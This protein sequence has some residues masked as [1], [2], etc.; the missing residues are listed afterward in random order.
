MLCK[1]GDN[2]RTVRISKEDPGCHIVYT[3]DGR[4]Q[5]VGRNKNFESCERI[6]TNIRE[7]LGKAGWNCRDV[8]EKSAVLAPTEN[9]Q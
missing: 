2:V 6:M 3:K 1:L 5:T 4:D 7:N 9:K 8:S